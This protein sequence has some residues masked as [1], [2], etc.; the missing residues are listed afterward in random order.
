MFRDVVGEELTGGRIPGVPAA[1]VAVLVGDGRDVGVAFDLGDDA[2]RADQRRVVVGPVAGVDLECSLALERAT[3]VGDPAGEPIRVGVA[4]VTEARDPVVRRDVGERVLDRRGVGP[5]R[6]RVHVGLRIVDPLGGHFGDADR[7]P[8]VL[9]DR[10][11][12]C[13][14]SGRREPLRV[15]D[16]VGQDGRL[17]EV[18]GRGEHRSQ[19][20]SLAGLVDAEGHTRRGR[21]LGK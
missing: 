12:E 8:I 3:G 11:G 17:L 7:D 18:D 5:D 10:F 21:G 15:R 19:C 1:D 20:R 9:A 14:P 2:R 4:G 6:Q 16:P 13:V